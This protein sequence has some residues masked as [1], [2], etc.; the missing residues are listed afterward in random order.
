MTSRLT[1]YLL[2]ISVVK[3]SRSIFLY[4]LYAITVI[5]QLFLTHK[6][7]PGFCPKSCVTTVYHKQDKIFRKLWK[8]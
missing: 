3:I 2:A 7:V 1:V 8:D 5:V 6:W 4:G